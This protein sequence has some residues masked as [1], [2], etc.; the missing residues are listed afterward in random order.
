[1]P[2]EPPRPSGFQIPAARLA[3]GIFDV[4][5]R[6]AI[7]ISTLLLLMAGSALLEVC[8]IGLL[9]PYFSLMTSPDSALTP[10]PL[11]ALISRVG[12]ERTLLAVGSLL[13][14]LNVFKNVYLALLYRFKFSFLYE[15]QARL[16]TRL[17]GKYMRSD[18]A[19]HLRRHS[20]EALRVI[21]TDVF[22]VFDYV[23]VPAFVLL[24]ESF[25]LLALITLVVS[26]APGATVLAGG[27]LVALCA[28]FYHGLRRKLAGVAELEKTHLTAM[29]RWI[30]QGLG[31]FKE[32]KVL[33]GE[34][35]FI[36][37]YRT[38]RTAYAGFM[39]MRHALSEYPRL[40]V[41]MIF[42][43]SLLTLALIAVSRGT[44]MR[45][46]VPHL[47]LFVTAAV[48]I[49]PGANRILIAASTIKT[50][51]TYLDGIQAE[52]RSAPQDDPAPQSEVAHSLE[53]FPPL[54]R[55]IVLGGVEFRYPGT[56]V[57]AVRSVSMSIPQ[58]SFVALVGPSGGGKSTVVDIILGLL[59]PQ[60]GSIRVDGR[61]ISE[62][63]RGW[64]RRIGLV[65]QPVYL[66][67]A[68]IRNNIAFGL[69]DDQIE[70]ARVWQALEDSQMAAFVRSLPDGLDTL[71]GESGGRL[72]G[73][74]RQR[75]GIARA[76]YRDPPV[77]V[78]D[79]ATTGLDNET[80]AEIAKVIIGLKGRK[81]IIS[82][83]HKLDRLHDVDKVFLMSEGR[84]SA[85][86]TFIDLLRE[87]E[88]FRSLVK[89]GSP[90]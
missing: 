14:A 31:G 45:L 37:A 76:L 18:Y 23:I 43:G 20:S 90:A 9:V 34:D 80:E 74:Q 15:M 42:V 54:A 44:D 89:A 6:R 75:I 49:M 53:E 10:A 78:L 62:N 2:P 21:N 86:G 7:P 47:V 79:E 46:L 66:Y 63:L 59:R 28:A 22:M 77:L 25:V 16:A 1:M 61:D 12:L 19:A 36:S 55:D 81:T 85:S 73:G 56:Q 67:D 3:S 72:S 64:R 8:G 33:G 32:A 5:E 82:V 39:G 4:L 88:G 11:H 52:L 58:G 26:A 41:E 51:L 38:H 71:V 48:R 57:S 30:Q 13:L 60:A 50:N 29:V 84:V 40:F 83:I 68:P 70:E 24:T 17:F 69:E 87:S 27:A 65:A 35:R